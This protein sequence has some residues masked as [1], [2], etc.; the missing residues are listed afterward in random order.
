M[1]QQV[2]AH[3]RATLLH[4]IHSPYS[5]VFLQGLNIQPGMHVLELGCGFGHMLPWLCEQ[6]GPEG[7]VVALD[8]DIA[9]VQHIQHNHKNQ[10][11]K[12]IHQ[13]TNEL[14]LG[15]QQFDIIYCRFFLMY[16]D[17]PVSL[18]QML[19]KHLK[20]GGGYLALEEST[21]STAFAYPNNK[22]YNQWRALRQQMGATKHFHFEI[23]N[24]L[25][26][27]MH[28][29][30]MTN[31]DIDF[32]QPILR[33]TEERMMNAQMLEEYQQLYIDAGLCSQEDIAEIIAGLKAQADN[34]AALIAIPRTSQVIAQKLD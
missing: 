13:H 5:E 2:L 16:V 24:Q 11:L 15:D 3:K 9:R 14:D 7:S 20:P 26:S 23:G 33:T 10:R 17:D 18:L 32:A 4:D 27:M 1:T 28:D 6:V 21:A 30:G 12:V 8:S 22:A 25:F 19:K 29:C 31:I 34:P